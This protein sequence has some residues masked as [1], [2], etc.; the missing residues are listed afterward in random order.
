MINLSP[1]KE[2][3]AESNTSISF[4]EKMN[5]RKPYMRF[6]GYNKVLLLGKRARLFCG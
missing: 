4:P 2:I 1:R 5:G 6:N 3:E